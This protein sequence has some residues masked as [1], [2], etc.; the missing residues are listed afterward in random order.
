MGMATSLASEDRLMHTP[1]SFLSWRAL[2]EATAPRQVVTHLTHVE[3]LVWTNYHSGAAA[4]EVYLTQVANVLKGHADKAYNLSV[5]VDG[6]PSLVAGRD[7][8]DGKFFVA[9]KSAL[10]KTPR[11]A[12][13]IA[14]IESLYGHAPGLVETLKVAYAALSQLNWTTVLQGDLMFVPS[15]RQ[16]Q[17]IDGVPHVTF[18]PNTI[19]YGIPEATPLGQRVLAASIG[20]AFHTTYT[21]SSLAT[22]RATPG[23]NLNTLG[24]SSDVLLFPTQYQDVSGSVSMTAAESREIDA[25]LAKIKAQTAT[26]R[27]NPF[28]QALQTTPAL[29]DLLMQF[30]NQLVR[31]GQSITPEPNEFVAR[32]VKFLEQLEAKESA[33]RKSAAGKTTVREKYLAFIGTVKQLAQTLAP[34]I[35]WQQ[36]VIDAKLALITKLNL[37]T[38]FS[39]F[40]QGDGGLTRGDHEGFVASD[41]RGGFVKLV[42]RSGFSQLNLTQGRFR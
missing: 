9:T 7:P 26:L 29:R 20:I 16:R 4:A 14:D 3:D 30:Q 21:G 32:F 12:K 36:L 38:E 17:S 28:L 19:V 15:L 39:P 35:R 1:P 24:A 22:L 13:S 40:L 25:K 8:D 42:D 33:A 23:A 27:Q 41:R 37:R 11:V 10:G 18:K 6:A 34:V 31:A 5:K 2:Q